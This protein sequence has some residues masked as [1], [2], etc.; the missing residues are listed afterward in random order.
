[1]LTH[2]NQRDFPCTWGNCQYAFKTKGS[3]KRHMRRHTG[4]PTGDICQS[5]F[6]LVSHLP[7]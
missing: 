5:K 6:G 3:L 7:D 1:M 4:V 2:S